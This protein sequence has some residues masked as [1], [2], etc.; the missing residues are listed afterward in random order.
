MIDCK[1]VA[2]KIARK[3][4]RQLSEGTGKVMLC[5]RFLACSIPIAVG[6]QPQGD[7]RDLIRC[8]LQQRVFLS[9]VIRLCSME[10]RDF[11]NT[12]PSNRN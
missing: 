5:R 4:W 10:P 11:A 8:F 6:T 12:F 2:N 7:C 1:Y 9:V 3:I